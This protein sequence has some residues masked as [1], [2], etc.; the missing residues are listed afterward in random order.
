MQNFGTEQAGQNWSLAAL[1]A[2]SSWTSQKKALARR[3]RCSGFVVE[4]FVLSCTGR[5]VWT[6][7]ISIQCEKKNRF[8]CWTPEFRS[9]VEKNLENHWWTAAAIVVSSEFSDVG[10][11]KICGERSRWRKKRR[12]VKYPVNVWW[13]SA[14][15]T[16]RFVYS[17]LGFFF[18]TTG[19]VGE[20]TKC[21]RKKM[22]GGIDTAV[23]LSAV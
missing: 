9:D 8:S 11:Q 21:A 2:D 1:V 10:C 3:G 16:A 23:I 12:V 4:A 20:A 5:T 22:Q 13:L 18:G 6:N 17:F 15:A 7:K 19:S 14:G